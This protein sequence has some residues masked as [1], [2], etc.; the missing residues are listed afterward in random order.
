MT[1][2]CDQCD[3]NDHESC[4]RV[5]GNLKLC[6][7]CQ[8]NHPDETF[9]FGCKCG[10]WNF[11]TVSAFLEKESN[12]MKCPTCE[13]SI[14]AIYP[15]EADECY[16]DGICKCVSWNAQ[17]MIDHMQRVGTKCLNCKRWISQD[18][19]AFCENYKKM[20]DPTCRCEHVDLNVIECLINSGNE[21]CPS[22]KKIFNRQ[23]LES[24]KLHDPVNH[25]AHYQSEGM[26]VIDVIEAFNL[27][28]PLGNAVKY[29]LRA[30]KKD[31]RLQDLQKAAWYINHE[32]NK[33]IESHSFKGKNGY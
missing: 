28:F 29:I 11:K 1:A 3:R 16:D 33:I 15:D 9:I 18:C 2:F 6:R 32:I 4:M 7:H 13:Q 30:G 22:C 12:F 10:E 5:I 25:P 31:N 24:K 21:T 17:A 26:E 27:G 20:N 19:L 8:I 14:C 23:M